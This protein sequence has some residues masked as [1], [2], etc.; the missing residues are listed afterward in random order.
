[1]YFVYCVNFYLIMILKKSLK[2]NIDCISLE[3]AKTCAIKTKIGLYKCRIKK[4]IIGL[5]KK[6]N[7]QILFPVQVL[8]LKKKCCREI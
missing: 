6:P 7:K 1:M 2:V 5:K 4:K 3:C 8:N